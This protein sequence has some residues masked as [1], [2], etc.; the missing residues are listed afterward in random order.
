MEVEVLRDHV[1]PGHHLKN[2]QVATLV[3]DLK[4]F[5][6]VELKQ[7]LACEEAQVRAVVNATIALRPAAHEHKAQQCRAAVDVR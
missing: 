6:R 4:T 1:D 7:I 2:P 5:T 3:L